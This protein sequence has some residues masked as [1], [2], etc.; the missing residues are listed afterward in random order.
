MVHLSARLHARQTLSQ[1]P[2]RTPNS[3]LNALQPRRATPAALE[4]GVGTGVRSPSALVNVRLGPKI[5]PEGRGPNRPNGPNS[6][7]CASE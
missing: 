2:S 5:Q 4:G 7:L 3:H 1:N 6:H